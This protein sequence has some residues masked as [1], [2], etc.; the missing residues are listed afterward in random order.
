MRLML[1]VL[2]S[3][4]EGGKTIRTENGYRRAVDPAIAVTI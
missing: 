2:E 3:V 1:A 4:S